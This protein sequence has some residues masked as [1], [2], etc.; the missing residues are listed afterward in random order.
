MNSQTEELK[1]ANRQLADTIQ[2]SPSQVSPGSAGRH[3]DVKLIDMKAMNRKKYDGKHETP[4]RTW[5]KSV[6]AYCNASK[7]GFRKFLRWVETQTSAIDRHLLSTFSWEH[8]EAEADA[9]YEFLL[10]HTTED[11]QQLVELQDEN[12]PEAWRQLSIRFDPIGEPFVFDQMSSLMEVPRC[13][14]LMDPPAALTKWERSLR[15]FSERTGG[16][17]AVPPRVKAPHLVQDDPVEYDE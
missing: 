5:A 1:S 17:Q 14:Q 10:L 13:K 7:P 11:T 3:L 6:R 8:K 12:G 15:S 16:S 9:L 4:Y 2:R